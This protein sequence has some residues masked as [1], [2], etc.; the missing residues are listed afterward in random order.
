MR[1]SPGEVLKSTVAH[2]N[3]PDNE[4]I[5]DLIYAWQGLDNKLF[6]WDEN[7]S[8]VLPTGITFPLASLLRELL[9]PALL[10]RSLK[11]QIEL[12]RRNKQTGIIAQA[13]MSAIDEELSNYLRIIGEIESEI[14]NCPDA[15]DHVAISSA[16]DASL[17]ENNKEN[18]AQ[19]SSGKGDSVSS[20]LPRN[21]LTLRMCLYLLRE[22]ISGLRLL[23]S[24]VTEVSTNHRHG[25]QILSV[26]HRY[27]LNG[28]DFVKTFAEKLL[29]RA[30]F[31][32]YTMLNSWVSIGHLNDPFDEMFVALSSPSSAATAIDSYLFR[33]DKVPSYMDASL[34]MRAF[35]TGKTLKFLRVDCKDTAWINERRT[36][37]TNITEYSMMY[38]ALAKNHTQ[39][40]ERLGWLMRNDLKLF[41]HL[42]GLKDY[43]F[44]SKGEFVQ[45]LIDEAFTVL[46]RP[47]TELH[48]HHLTGILET[49]LRGCGQVQGASRVHALQDEVMNCV[50]A[51]MLEAGHGETGWELFTLEYR[52]TGPLKA[53]LLDQYSSRAYLRI[54]NFLWRIK[55][56][57]ASLQQAWSHLALGARSHRLIGTKWIFARKICQQMMHFA[58]ELQ[59]YLSYEV[60]ESSWTQLQSKLSQSSLSIDETVRAHHRYL[61]YIMDKGLFSGDN[62]SKDCSL[63]LTSS[64]HSQLKGIL[65][66]STQVSE[67]QILARSSIP[68][69]QELLKSMFRSIQKEQKRFHDTTRHLVRTLTTVDD[70]EMRFL[71]VRL[72]FNDFYKNL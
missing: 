10:Y 51:R 71:A 48:R 68:E 36:K 26:I 29:K 69:E 24:I 27:T 55:W 20:A 35:E 5:R 62:I 45:I 53:V 67:M 8:I 19:P 40:V 13:L 61:K 66:F 50:D 59:Y 22:V 54:F 42:E 12:S 6:A 49:A 14:R 15:S 52:L 25:C 2:Q 70:E 43:M 39:V 18:M 56:V 58:H 47:A 1:L 57:S 38:K 3:P 30:S 7:G 31:P 28:N 41:V 32:L 60:I 44:L 33:S 17:Q 23:H 63:S 34:A 9:E 72:D 11:E 4:I 46:D 64:L 16:Q 65:R 21:A 37:F